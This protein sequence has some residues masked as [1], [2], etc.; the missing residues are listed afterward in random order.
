MNKSGR[1]LGREAV[2]KLEALI[3]DLEMRNEY[4]PLHKA[5]TALHLSNICKLLGIVRTT[6]STN[7]A[8]RETLKRYA[9][10]HGIEYSLKGRVAPS[11]EDTDAEREFD[12]MVPASRL[13]EATQ[14][15]AAAERRNAEL[16][17]ENVYLRGQIMRDNEVAEL[18]AL[19]G[20]INP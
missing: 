6:V 8:F 3:A 13:R 7:S 11:E 10:R 20:R 18:I 19:G 2:L 14:R 12:A 15:L 5:G 1:V 17:A 4:L 9:E 16:K